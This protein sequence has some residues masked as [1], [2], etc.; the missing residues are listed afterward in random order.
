MENLSISTF[1]KSWIVFYSVG[2]KDENYRAYLHNL[3]RDSKPWDR[4]HSVF[5]PVWSFNP[6]LCDFGIEGDMSVEEAAFEWQQFIDT[7][8]DK[9]LFRNQDFF[10]VVLTPN[11]FG[12][13]LRTTSRIRFSTLS[14]LGGDSQWEYCRSLAK[15]VL[16]GFAVKVNNREDEFKTQGQRMA[17]YIDVLQAIYNDNNQRRPFFT[18]GLDSYRNRRYR[19]NWYE[20]GIFLF[21]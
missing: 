3:P 4:C 21:E 14:D 13:G 18:G 2:L 9:C 1:L 17:A 11:G 15:L 6:D 10:E 16:P 7:W 20:I 8:A 5:D 19:I 12:L